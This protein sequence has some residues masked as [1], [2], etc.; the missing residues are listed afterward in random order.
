MDGRQQRASAQVAKVGRSDPEQDG[1]C[2]LNRRRRRRSPAGFGR[3]RIHI[4]RFCGQRRQQAAEARRRH[5]RDVA[6]ERQPGIGQHDVGAARGQ[7]RGDRRGAAAPA[8]A[9]RA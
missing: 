6:A 1:G 5:L 9:T 2:R 3:R 4:Q 8:T 7:T